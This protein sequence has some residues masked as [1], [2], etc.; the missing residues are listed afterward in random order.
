M[1]PSDIFP[2][3]THHYRVRF[4]LGVLRA[5]LRFLHIASLRLRG[6]RI[7]RTFVLVIN[8][9]HKKSFTYDTNFCCADSGHAMVANIV[10]RIPYLGLIAFCEFSR[11]S[12]ARFRTK[13]HAYFF[14]VHYCFHSSLFFSSGSTAVPCPWRTTLHLSS[15]VPTFFC[16]ADFDL[17]LIDFFALSLTLVALT[18]TLVDLCFILVALSS[19]SVELCLD[20]VAPFST[21][22]ALS[23]TLVTLSSTSVVNR[24]S[25]V[26]AGS[27]RVV[28]EFDFVCIIDVVLST[29][30][31]SVCCLF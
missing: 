27:H 23:P 11:P 16:I 28:V 7:C 1:A 13:I 18:S 24:C 29:L 5:C 22:S 21:L 10:W 14:I 6:Y 17:A 20:L 2:S 25:L 3:R 31:V 19:T 15:L 30:V 9:A 26:R 12:T 4:L 8:R